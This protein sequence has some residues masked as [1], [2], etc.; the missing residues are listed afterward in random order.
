MLQQTTETQAAAVDATVEKI[1]TKINTLSTEDPTEENAVED[2]GDKK[3]KK[4]KK[5]KI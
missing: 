1:S 4:R 2:S 3:K 5:K